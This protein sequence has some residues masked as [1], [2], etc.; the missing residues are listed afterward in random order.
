MSKTDV[1]VKRRIWGVEEKRSIVAEAF[2]HAGGVSLVARRY[3]LHPH[4]IY[5]W[6]RVLTRGARLPDFLRIETKPDVEALPLPVPLTSVTREVPPIMTPV[7][8]VEIALPDGVTMR[9]PVSAGS[10]F[11]ADVA[12]FLSRGAS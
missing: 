7:D 6:R 3:G 4:Q 9:M 10:A 11:V 12:L 8:Q 2:S 1:Y 5:A